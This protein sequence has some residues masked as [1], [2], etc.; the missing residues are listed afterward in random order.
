M[1]DVDAVRRVAELLSFSAKAAGINQPGD[2][3]DF[4][5]NGFPPVRGGWW[6][7]EGGG[8]GGGGGGGRGDGDGPLQMESVSH[9]FISAQ[10]GPR[11]ARH[12]RVC[13]NVTRARS[14]CT[15]AAAASLAQS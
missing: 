10:F 8:G 5:F 6:E 15:R 3:W 2:N 12:A 4:G 13:V 9:A 14:N 11:G 1:I 7:G